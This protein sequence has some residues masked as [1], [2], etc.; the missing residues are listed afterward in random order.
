LLTLEI[1]SLF[2]D[3]DQIHSP[4][5]VAANEE[6]EQNRLTIRGRIRTA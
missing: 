3:G 2:G 5:L 1:A 4:D 6:S